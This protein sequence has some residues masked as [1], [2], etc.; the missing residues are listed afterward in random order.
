M[1]GEEQMRGWGSTA[2]LHQ[3]GEL[4]ALQKQTGVSTKD[5]RVTEGKS[6]LWHKNRQ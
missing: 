5:T 6:K 1:E 4:A 3:R 2:K